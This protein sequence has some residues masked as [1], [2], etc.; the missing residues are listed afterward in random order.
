MFRVISL[1]TDKVL[2]GIA[3]LQESMSNDVVV[4]FQVIFHA[5]HQGGIGKELDLPVAT[6]LANVKKA[7]GDLYLPS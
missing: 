1:G 5:L 3:L 4:K 2:Q 6:Q 7:S